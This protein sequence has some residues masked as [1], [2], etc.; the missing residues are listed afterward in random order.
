MKRNISRLITLVLAVFIIESAAAEEL[1]FVTVNA[2]SGMDYSGI[3]S[4]DEYESDGD[5]E[6]RRE[7]LTSSLAD[8]SAD[9]I[10]LNGLNPAGP[11]AGAVSGELGMKSYAWVS[12]SGVRIGPVSLP[13]N[14]KEGDAVL[15]AEGLTVEP[16]GRMQMKG[17]SAGSAVTLFA[18]D[19]VQAAGCLVSTGD[20]SFYVFSVVWTESLFADKESLLTLLSAYSNGEISGEEYTGFT[21]NAVEGAAARLEQ[22]AETLSFINSVA[23][24]TPVVLMGSLNALP[25][26]AELDLLTDAGFIDIYARSGRGPGY[27]VDM[28]GNSSFK[29]IPEGG[30]QKARALLSGQYRSDYILMRGRGMKPVS[31][32]IVLDEP[33]YGVFPSARYG[34]KAVIEFSPILSE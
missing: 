25:G 30:L 12:R 21:E 28:A 27:T 9:V 13:A 26:S 7:I 22:A 31:A 29:K 3:I 33:V 6:F 5:R 16:A 10:V 17:L 2:W 1:S 34:V 11:A 32:E 14:L 23:G 18:R 24:E 20:V 19:G 4:C 8:T 15:T